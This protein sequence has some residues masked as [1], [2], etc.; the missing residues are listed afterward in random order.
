MLRR[1]IEKVFRRA[2]K[3]RGKWI[4]CSIFWLYSSGDERWGGTLHLAPAWR[5]SPWA[6]DVH[7]LV[8]TTV[9]L[10]GLST[11][12]TAV[13]A[14]TL[15]IAAWWMTEAVPLPVTS[16]LPIVLFPVLG[17]GSVVEVA[18]P[19][20]DPIVFLFL[21]GFLVALAIERWGLHQ[22]IAL[23]VL[24][25]VG[26][27]TSRLVLGFMLVTAF[28]S[29]WVSNTATAMMMVPI[30]MAVVTQ[31]HGLRDSGR[32]ALTY[33][34]ETGSALEA[35]TTPPSTFGAALML[36]IAYAASIGG[37]A[38]L[39]GTPPNAILAGIAQSALGIEIGFVQWMTFAL[40][41]SVVFLFVTWLVLIT[42]LRPEIG[43]M[44]EGNAVIRDQMKALGPMSTG[45][46]RVVVVFLVVV[47]GWLLRP[48]VLEPLFPGISDTSIA[49]VGGILVFVIP[50]NLR[51]GEFLLTWEA[52]TR[53][54]WGVLLLFG[55]GFSLARAFQLSGLDRWIAEQLTALQGID[56]I[57]V[58]LAVATLVVFLTEVTSNTATTS[59][60]IP[61]MVGLGASLVVSPL[62][63]MVT[64][65]VAA[66]FAFMLPVAT[67][68]NAIVFGSGYI[69]IPQMARVGFWLNLLGILFLTLVAYLWL[70][71]AWGL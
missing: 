5:V 61:V 69:S 34:A 26:D 45:E 51:R 29:M 67:P 63:L 47:L 52:T 71:I 19:Y 17:V 13:L 18:A 48:F 46:R 8:Q 56:V 4:H 16:L 44:P 31:L 64:V 43:T 14:S 39:I 60:F 66:S 59:L 27:D 12:A 28:L 41:I 68:P 11:E 70:P 23:T 49:L 54:P 65:S 58:L 6:G 32:E 7:S 10:P 50:V 24:L 30:G 21:G 38:T 1:S 36:G 35:G 53:V 9:D 42:V 22:R 20:A 3:R 33:P 37:I 15:W 40:P 57:W 25:K 55:A 2:A 62:L